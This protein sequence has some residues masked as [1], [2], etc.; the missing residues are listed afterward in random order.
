LARR[1]RALYLN[2]RAAIAMAPAVVR[3][4]AR[5]SGRDESWQQRQLREFEQVA[6]G[7]VVDQ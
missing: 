3:L 1:T 5:E 6:A 4:M 7:F 2:S